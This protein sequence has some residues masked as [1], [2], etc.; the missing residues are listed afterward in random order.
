MNRPLDLR[1]C[2]DTLSI[3]AAL[4][5]LLV[6]VRR[7]IGSKSEHRGFAIQQPDGSQVVIEKEGDNPF[8]HESLKGL[9]DRHVRAFGEMYRGRFIADVV[10]VLE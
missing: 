6:Q 4:E 1:S 10:D 9:Q 2:G 3:V 5:G 8:E 7:D